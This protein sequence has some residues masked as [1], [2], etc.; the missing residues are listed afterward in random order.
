MA[1]ADK[2]KGFWDFSL[3]LYKSQGIEDVCLRLQNEYRA[4]VNLLLWCCWR[5]WVLGLSYDNAMLSAAQDRLRP[6]RQDVLEPL[7][8]LRRKAKGAVPTYEALKVAELEAERHAQE[9]ILKDD[10]DTAVAVEGK[11]AR[12]SLCH[13]ALRHYL[14]DHLRMPEGEAAGVIDELLAALKRL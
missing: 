13:Q 7:R 8:A 5:A 14:V 6:W 11:G 12:L 2:T 9:L 4:D 1:K 3:K 10:A